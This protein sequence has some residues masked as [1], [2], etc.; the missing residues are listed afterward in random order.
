MACSACGSASLPDARFC[1][2]CGAALSP[3]GAPDHPTATH[4]TLSADHDSQGEREL[5]DELPEGTTAMFVMHQ[6]PKR[7]SRIHLDADKVSIGRHPDSDIFLDDVTVSRRHA[8]MV[9]LGDGFE[10]FD[11]GSLNGTYVNQDRVDRKFLVNGDV[12]QIG[13]FKLVYVSLGGELG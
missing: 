2:S 11:V 9:R 10:V 5:V 12:V 4:D 6:G 8:E 13:K 1:S 7:G 3:T